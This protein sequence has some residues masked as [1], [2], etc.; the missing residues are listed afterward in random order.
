MRFLLRALSLLALVV[1]V[2][3]AVVDMIRSVAGSEVVITPLGA[4]WYSISADTLN[5][6]QAVIQRNVHP[7]IWDPVVQWILLQ[8]T[9]AVFLV[10]SLFFYL[11]AWRRP[12]AAGR[13][14][15]R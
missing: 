1:A 2:I 9:W 13:F 8:P 4:A 3:S 5:L 7:Y 11:I 15:V 10:L 14:A 6:T 12:K